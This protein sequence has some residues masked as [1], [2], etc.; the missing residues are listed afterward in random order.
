MPTKCSQNIQIFALAVTFAE[1]LLVFEIKL[2]Q[3]LL[4][5]AEKSSE[6]FDARKRLCENYICLREDSFV[7][8]K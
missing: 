2:L 1:D 8:R 4:E 5:I 6:S 7:G 3:G